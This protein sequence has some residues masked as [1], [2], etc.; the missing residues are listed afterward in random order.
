MS[1]TN[2]YINK[3]TF[4]AFDFE[5]TGLYPQKD[6]IIEIGA[7]RFQNTNTIKTFHTLINPLMPISREASR[8]NGITENMLEDK[9]LIA[10]ALP[11]FLNFINNS[12][13]IAHNAS[14][15]MAFF[16][17]ELLC[18]NLQPITNHVIDTITLAK[19]TLQ[20]MRSY[21]LE[22]LAKDLSIKINRFHRALNDAK[23]CKEI[24]LLCIARIPGSR[25]ILLK[26]LLSLG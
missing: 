3:L 18:L 4:T 13:L 2:T 19:N 5:T 11:Q 15:D 23:V 12:V 6:K 25:E 17:H 9:P 22:N 7:V 20:S 1:S 21:S 10:Q 8:I 24:F 14:F 16:D 26:D